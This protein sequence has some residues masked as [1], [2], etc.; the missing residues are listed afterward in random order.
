MDR[1]FEISHAV[2][3]CSREDPHDRPGDLPP[4]QISGSHASGT[5]ETPNTRLRPKTSDAVHGLLTGH[6]SISFQEIRW[7]TSP[8][9]CKVS[10][11]LQPL[12]SL[13]S[14]FLLPRPSGF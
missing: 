11:Q 13:L 4:P 2:S 10:M 12:V 3:R 1:L 9:A 6:S 5:S 14:T 8:T 7:T